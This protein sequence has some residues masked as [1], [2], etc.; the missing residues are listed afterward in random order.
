MKKCIC[1][2]GLQFCSVCKNCLRCLCDCVVCRECERRYLAEGKNLCPRCQICRRCCTCRK[3]PAFTPAYKLG[4]I[5]GKRYLSR[6][7]RTVGVEMEI[8]EWK[9]LKPPIP[10]L[11]FTVAHDWSVKPSEKEMVISPMRGDAVI[12]GMLSLSRE[13]HKHQCEVNQTCALHVHV[14]AEDYSAWEI[15]RLLEVYRKLEPDIYRYLI[16][17]H[18]HQLPE[19]LHYCQM[20]TQLHLTC[21]RCERYDQQFPNQR[22]PPEHIDT[23]LARMSMATTT[24]DI[25]LCLIRMLYGLEN[26]ASHPED[27][28]IRK[29][30]KYEWSRYFG[31][32]LH[33]WQHRLTIEWRMKEATTDAVEMVC[34]PLWCGWV[35]HAV[36]QMNDIQARNPA[37]SVSYITERYMP[38]ILREWVKKKIDQI[39]F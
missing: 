34:W 7:P 14:G 36:T 35:V 24:G 3:A 10:N 23:T 1:G 12:R 8:G 28:H 38:P 6:L 13:M 11:H 22:I 33:S 26:P 32:N 37:M 31:L 21:K 9:G 2:Q 27:V 18:R 15:R 19:A 25:K 20:M 17:P 30:G 5:E 39:Q 4:V 29:G 16:A